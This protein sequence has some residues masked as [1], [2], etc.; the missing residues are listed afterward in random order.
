MKHLATKILL[1]LFAVSMISLA[2]AYVLRIMLVNDFHQFREGEMLDRAHWLTATL[3]TN[4]EKNSGWTSGEI[5]DSAINALMIGLEITVRNSE[6]KELMTTREAMERLSTSMREKVAGTLTAQRLSS[7]GQMLTFPLFS[8][9]EEIG[10]VDITFLKREKEAAF[11]TRTDRFLIISLLGAAFI[12]LILSIIFSKRIVNPLKELTDAAQSISGGDLDKKVKISG[13]DEIA[14]LGETFNLMAEHLKRQ[15]ILR[16]K[17]ITNVAHELR[18]PITALKGELEAMIDGIIPM[19]AE[20]LQSLNE[21]IGRLATLIGG[22]EELSQTE[23]RVFSIKKE[24]FSLYPFLDHIVERYRPL[25]DAKGVT[26]DLQCT[27]TET[28]FADPDALSRIVI[29]LIANSLAATEKGNIVNVKAEKTDGSSV[30]KIEDNGKGIAEENLPFI[31]ER[32]FTTS[33][34]LGIGLAI[35]KEL[36]EAQ[37]ATIEVHSDKKKG[38]V[39]TL[40]LPSS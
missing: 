17:L 20:Q 18:T 14:R 27:E 2:S 35:V 26:V 24:F 10:T 31:F 9:G 1:L 22:I 25:F 19:S 32:F 23:A 33:G 3:E 4:H 15:D 16:R 39:F 40:M 28:V 12:V 38:T 8:E 37:N 21:E 13:K 30:I 7:R 29:N 6:G 36:A 11:V 34:S 5:A